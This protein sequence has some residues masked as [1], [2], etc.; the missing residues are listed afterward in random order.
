MVHSTLALDD[1]SS[2]FF[3][4]QRHP[5]LPA[6]CAHGRQDPRPAALR[7]RALSACLAMPPA[8]PLIE[9]THYLW[10]ASPAGASIGY[11]PSLTGNDETHQHRRT[12]Q[13]PRQCNPCTVACPSRPAASRPPKAGRAESLPTRQGH[14]T[15]AAWAGRRTTNAPRHT[16]TK[17]P[18][19]PQALWVFRIHRPQVIKGNAS[20]AQYRPADWWSNKYTWHVSCLEHTNTR[21]VVL[22][23]QSIG[24]DNLTHPASGTAQSVLKGVAPPTPAH[25]KQRANQIIII[26]RPSYRAANKQHQHP[27]WQ[28]A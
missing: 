12:P 26:A 28:T 16:N 13:T 8:P 19:E 10:R 18:C 6:L 9:H 1:N 4:A 21:P 7:P 22:P 24:Y 15:H 3:S 11:S 17:G 27:A 25:C 20:T 2:S 23:T 14:D 5:G